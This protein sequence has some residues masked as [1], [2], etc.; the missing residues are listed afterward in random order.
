MI[1]LTTELKNLVK[2]RISV[3]KC[4]EID[5]WDGTDRQG[6]A[7]VGGSRAYPIQQFNQK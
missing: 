6:I 2:A 7:K 1:L 4:V 5:S 3:K